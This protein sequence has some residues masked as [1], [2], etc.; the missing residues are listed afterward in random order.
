MKY[1]LKNLTRRNFLSASALA[2]GAYATSSLVADSAL[3]AA[4]KKTQ[5]IPVVFASDIG[6]DIDD[7]WALAMLLKCP[8]LDL[9]LA[10][11]DSGYP[12]YRARIMA[13][14]LEI[15]G[16]SH[17]PVGLGPKNDDEKVEAK[18]ATR[19]PPQEAWLNNYDLASYKGAV[20]Q[21]GAK[22]LVETIMKS[23][24]PITLIAVGPVPTVAAALAMEPRIAERARF[25]G[26][27]G[28]I[29]VG[30]DGVA[31]PAAEF[32]VKVSTKSAQKV[33]SAPW[34]I[35]ITPLDTCGIVTLDGERY[36]R[37]LK[38]KDP[39]VNALIDNYR[40]WSRYVDKTSDKAE[41][42]S[43]VLFD[44]VAVYLAM[45]QDLCVMERLSIRVTDDGFTKIDQSGT[46][47]NVAMAWKNLD[48]YKDFL[49]NRL[50]AK[51]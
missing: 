13:K 6:G 18:Q 1:E 35:T 25:V 48:A 41:K 5:R 34:D 20:H 17:V 2:T 21:D 23:P 36:Q 27:H 26:M 22:A 29:K 46:P 37:L 42:G 49:V 7:T 19:A 15:A 3:G 4:S 9:K 24:Q 28:S 50:L 31:T 47:M 40:I 30:Y 33:L 39:I 16:H 43:T 51:T 10:V 12:L 8:E 38:S 44:T 11:T 14:F 45:Q 32:N